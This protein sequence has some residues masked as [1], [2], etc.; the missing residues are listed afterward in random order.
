VIL[1]NT[2]MGVAAGTALLMVPILALEL[3][4]IRGGFM[5]VTMLILALVLFILAHSV[6]AADEFDAWVFLVEGNKV[7]FVKRD[8][9]TKG[10]PDVPPTTLTV[11]DSVQVLH[12][13]LNPETKKYEGALV[14][15]G[16][17]Y[18]LFKKITAI[19][20]D[21]SKGRRFH[22]TQLVTNDENQITEIRLH[23]DLVAKLVKVKDDVIKV[24]Q[25]PGG[26]FTAARSIVSLWTTAC[27]TTSRSSKVGSTPRPKIF[28]LRP[29]ELYSSGGVLPWDALFAGLP[30]DHVWLT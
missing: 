22:L 3:L 30:P 18:P 1:Y 27:R 14:E 20:K 16:L 17:D 29:S 13:S 25:L 2:L 10:P 15:G 8:K 21:P 26:G 4:N 6:A 7:S 23:D 24:I 9:T 11:A 28:R 19:S 5:R 12:G